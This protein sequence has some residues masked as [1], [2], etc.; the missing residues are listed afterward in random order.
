MT[1]WRRALWACRRA[2]AGVRLRLP[3]RN[4]TAMHFRCR[5]VSVPCLCRDL[6]RRAVCTVQL[7]HDAG[8]LTAFRALR[9]LAGR[10]SCKRRRA[11]RRCARMFCAGTHGLCR[12]AGAGAAG[13]L[14]AW[15]GRPDMTARFA[16][17][18]WCAV[19]LDGG[20]HAR[21]ALVVVLVAFRL[22][23]IWRHDATWHCGA[24]ADFLAKIS[25]ALTK[26]C[27]RSK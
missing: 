3:P 23:H 12:R 16:R 19:D 21:L 6:Q 8:V 25:L 1:R 26:V 17:G 24:S 13:C 14:S 22:P 18:L 7:R 9:L 10:S 5:A 2:I 11:A 20:I 27:H 15:I 4:I